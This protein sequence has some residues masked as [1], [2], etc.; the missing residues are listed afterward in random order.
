MFRGMGIQ[1]VG[2]GVTAEDLQKMRE[3]KSGA[4]IE[5]KAEELMD[6]RRRTKQ[7]L[8]KISVSWKEVRIDLQAFGGLEFPVTLK[9]I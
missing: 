6:E 3:L 8:D 2:K 9:Y 1:S 4:Q 7:F 5:E